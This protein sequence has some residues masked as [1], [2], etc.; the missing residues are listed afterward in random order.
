MKKIFLS[1]L[2]ALSVFAVVMTGCGGDDNGG[3]GKNNA[4]TFTNLAANGDEKQMTTQLTLTFNA[5]IDGLAA[6]DITLSG[7]ANVNKGTVRAGTANSS[8]TRYI[9]PIN[10]FIESGTLS[11]EV[12]KSGYTITGSPK[13]ADI[14]YFVPLEIENPA[15][16]NKGET[17]A[18][19]TDGYFTFQEK[20]NRGNNMITY[21]FPATFSDLLKKY[22]NIN[23]FYTVAKL[24]TGDDE[25]DAKPMK[26]TIKQ[27]YD[28]YDNIGSGEAYPE[29]NHDGDGTWTYSLEYA[30]DNKKDGISIQYNNYRDPATEPNPSCAFKIK[31]TK[32]VFD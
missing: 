5:A 25:L 16:E 2:A 21:R 24:A 19:D 28:S 14:F 4:V 27:G 9:L 11:A 17:A 30:F 1:I 15:M 8:G 20:T 12:A 29:R 3:G 13:T 32:I 10:G 22:S 7:V 31:I 26:V 23:I 18:A 6:D